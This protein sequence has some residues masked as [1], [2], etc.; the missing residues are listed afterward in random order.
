VMYYSVDLIKREGTICTYQ[1]TEWVEV[2]DDYM[3]K[4]SF[5]VYYNEPC[6]VN[7]SCCMFES[8]RILCK[9][10]ISVLIRVNVTSLPEKYFLNRWRKDLKQKYKFI[11]SSYNPLKGNPSAEICF[12]LC[13]D[14]HVVAELALT[15]IEIYM[16]VKDH[17]RM[18]MKQLSGLGCKHN[19]PSQT[20]QVGSTSDLSV[21]DTMV[22]SNKVHSP[23]VKRTRGKPP[24]IRLVSAVKKAVVKKS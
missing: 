10:V 17:I 5:T 23:L 3:K 1:V 24:S 11:K 12:N 7:C 2:I 9:H 15:T 20:L 22:E 18:L 4:I 8:R 21:N 6:E 13:K 19:L 14:M 16:K